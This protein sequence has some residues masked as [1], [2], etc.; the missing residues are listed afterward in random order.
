MQEGGE[1]G[2]VAGLSLT[3]FKST[4]AHKGRREVD[5]FRAGTPVSSTS[6]F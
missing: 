2:K 3:E 1:N 4:S 6:P 5:I